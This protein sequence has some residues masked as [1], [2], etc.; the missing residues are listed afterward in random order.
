MY[1]LRKTRSAIQRRLRT[2]GYGA[3]ERALELATVEQQFS[4]LGLDFSQASSRTAQLINHGNLNRSDS[5]LHY[6]LFSAI[7]SVLDPKRVLEIG[8]FRGEFS[9]FL[10]QLF[11]KSQLQTW[12]LPD[13]LGSEIHDYA[14]NFR[15]YYRD[16]RAS[17]VSN[18]SSLKNVQQIQKDSTYLVRATEVFDLI[19]VDGDHSYPVVAFDILNAL[20]LISPVGWVVIDDVR[21][22]D[23]GNSMG[24][25]ESFE[26]IRHLTASGLVDSSLVYKRV[27]KPNRYW[28]DDRRRKHLAVLRP[29][30]QD[31][32]HQK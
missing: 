6:E 13:N 20:R 24:S 26:C 25:N 29:R 18:L 22:T 27:G 23:S 8:T 2:V 1:F 5:S 10:G 16:Q 31:S 9:A 7:S 14:A 19:W 17:R 21:L 12:D 11:P 15:T 3:N 4:K 28:R 32:E 30:P